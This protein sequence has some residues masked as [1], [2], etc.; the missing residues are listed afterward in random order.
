MKL[1]LKDSPIK[2]YPIFSNPLSI[3]L[4][5]ENAY[6]WIYNCFHQL[7]CNCGIAL[8]FYDF[9]YKN[10]PYL[11]VQNIDKKF[12]K[13]MGIDII[14]FL[15]KS[16]EEGKYIY[17]N[18][19]PKYIN[20][21]K[22]RYDWDVHDLFIYGFSKKR[23]QFYIA[24][25]F[26][27]GKYAYNECSF[28][29]LEDSL[30][31]LAQENENYI[32]LDG[33]IELLSLKSEDENL[34]GFDYSRVKQTLVD[35][36]DSRPTSCWN[37]QDFKWKYED[38]HHTFGVD[39]YRYIHK[40]IDMLDEMIA[41]ADYHIIWEHKKHWLDTVCYMNRNNFI[42]CK[43]DYFEK[44]FQ[45]LTNRALVARNLAIKYDVTNK[46]QIRNRMHNMY[47]E[48]EKFEHDLL[49]NFICVLK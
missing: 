38:S 26:D 43:G 23:K 42:K 18:V 31:F 2:V 33:C 37:V 16:L 24:D 8:S 13:T 7:I 17:M 5:N 20:A 12:I 46:M 45:E 28:D 21:Y 9:D 6:K 36:I 11:Q 34:G 22:L 35:Y 14:D 48:I 19:N 29:E 40:R 27:Y 10:C 41:L 30:N 1:K 32:M 49:Q 25:C 39:C 47:L 44:E 3:I 4:N 15:I